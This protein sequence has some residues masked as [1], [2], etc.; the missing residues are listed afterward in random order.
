MQAAII[1]DKILFSLGVFF[2]TAGKVRIP[3]ISRAAKAHQEQ[4]RSWSQNSRGKSFT[5][6]TGL[7]GEP[8]SATMRIVWPINNADMQTNLRARLRV[9]MSLKARRSTTVA[10]TKT[11]ERSIANA[12]SKV[13]TRT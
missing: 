13:K 4:A 8:I 1:S 5:L 10:R 11:M 3:I 7:N 9:G 2:S 12:K 6:N